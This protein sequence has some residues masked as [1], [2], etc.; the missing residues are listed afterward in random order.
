MNLGAVLRSALLCGGFAAALAT[1]GP[2]EVQADPV[3]AWAR[4]SPPRA[5]TIQGYGGDAME[6]SLSRDGQVLVFNN[7][8]DPPDQTDLHWA[9]RID[10]LTFR[11]EGLVSGAN[12]ADLDGVAT[13]SAGGRLCFISTR[14][15]R[16][17]LATVFC[18]AW[19]DGQ[20]GPSVLQ[21]AASPQVAGRLVFDLEQAADGET[22]ILADGRFTGAAAP[23]SADLRLARWRNGAFRLSPVD[24]RLFAAVN[25][26]GLE[27][28]PALSGDGLTLAFTR[29]SGWPPLARIGIWLARRGS[30]DAPFGRPVRIA[31]ITGFVEGPTFSPDGR[32]IYFHRRVGDRFSLWRVTLAPAGPARR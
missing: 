15:Y 1:G 21:I 26:S 23:A 11:Y 2:A 25:T 27:Y 30:T 17:T 19:R 24:D 28:A 20:A 16:Q 13:L 4:F 6:P 10:D 32:S 14:A 9:R 3:A 8:N 31:A 12:S 18:S 7:R 29:L 5:V 22:A